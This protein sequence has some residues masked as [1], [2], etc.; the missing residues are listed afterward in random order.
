LET[1]LL[2]FLKKLERSNKMKKICIKCGKKQEVLGPNRSYVEDLYLICS[3]CLPIHRDDTFPYAK[4]AKNE[5]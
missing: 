4:E 2:I 5:Y 1:G 3:A